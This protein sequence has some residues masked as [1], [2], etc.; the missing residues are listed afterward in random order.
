VTRH[1]RIAL[2]VLLV[3]LLPSCSG[4]DSNKSVAPT[5]RALV[6]ETIAPAYRSL[7]NAAADLSQSLTRCSAGIAESREAWRAARLAWDRASV[8]RLGPQVERFLVAA[9]DFWP[10]APEAVDYFADGFTTDLTRDRVAAL[11]SGAKGL[12]AI[13]RLLFSSSALE[14][15]RCAYAREL[16]EVIREGADGAAAD[17]EA[18]ADSFSR[19]KRALADVVSGLADSVYVLADAA[20]AMP[21]GTRAGAAPD[22]KLVRGREGAMALD[23]AKTQLDA[24]DAAYKKGVAPVLLSRARDVDTSMT[25]ALENARTAL[26]AITTDLSSAV[27]QQRDLVINASEACRQVQRMFA[28]QVASTLGLTLNV[29]AGD[30]D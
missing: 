23:D 1:V 22:V 19:D 2:F 4:G 5:M 16:A 30:G 26:S 6:V 7:G 24:I 10:T 18:R 14:G 25:T 20:L 21:A 13:E 9:V 3:F 17:W 28:T 15:R 11:G 27:T 8:F 12:P 29:A